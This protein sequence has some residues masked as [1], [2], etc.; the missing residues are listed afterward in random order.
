MERHVYWRS[1]TSVV[2]TGCRFLNVPLVLGGW[3]DSEVPSDVRN[4]KVTGCT[5]LNSAG[6]IVMA[7]GGSDTA[8]CGSN[9]TISGNKFLSS[10]RLAPDGG[11][12]SIYS[13]G[14]PLSVSNVTGATITGNVFDN[15]WGTNISLQNDADV[16][17]SGNTFLH[18]NEIHPT[19]ASARP[20]DASVI[21]LSH[22]SG[23]SL[24]DNRVYGAGPFTDA[25][26]KA[27]QD[28]TGATGLSDGLRDPAAPTASAVPKFGTVTVNW[29]PLPDAA[30]YSVGRAATPAGPYT[31]LASGLTT[32]PYMDSSAPAG[33]P[34][35][36]V[37]TAQGLPGGS[38]RSPVVWAAPNTDSVPV[39]L[40]AAY[41]VAGISPRTLSICRGADRRGRGLRA[42]PTAPRLSLSTGT[43]ASSRSARPP[44]PTP[45]SGSCSLPAPT[46]ACCCWPTTSAAPPP[47]RS[48]RRSPT[49]TGPTRPS[50]CG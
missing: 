45:G 46:A 4:I 14:Q 44:F 38:R 15:N 26:V 27:A 6:L 48:S 5:F 10:G 7:N 49:R 43:E 39:N 33:R 42:G 19:W 20:D 47:R 50:R 2:V 21:W 32:G 29:T 1:G 8:P 25:L 18:P 40:A 31:P 11:T 37:V 34:S 35:F 22:V 9:V 3:D 17:V 30:G 12:D 28:V 24:S 23:A 41:T 13:E 36:Y 16:H